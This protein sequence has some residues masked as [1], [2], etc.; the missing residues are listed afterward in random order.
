MHTLP[1][2]QLGKLHVKGPAAASPGVAI[3]RA[4]PKSQGSGLLVALAGA[5]VMAWLVLHRPEF[6]ARHAIGLAGIICLSLAYSVVTQRARNS[7]RLICDGQWLGASSWLVGSVVNL[8]ELAAV[9][10]SR[11]G[12]GIRELAFRSS[13]RELLRL[14]LRLWRQDEV[15][16]LLA[17]LRQTHPA[18]SFDLPT[19]LWL[20]QGAGR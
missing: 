16:D 2:E 8:G 7:R 19:R 13:S 6:C 9:E 10:C 5:A 20:E 12:R 1:Y 18:L 15:R 14:D 4:R 17:R 3:V 11:A